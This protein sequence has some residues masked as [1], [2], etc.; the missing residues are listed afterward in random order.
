MG[1]GVSVGGKVAVGIRVS[2]GVLVAVGALA[3]S[4]AYTSSTACVWMAPISSSDGPHAV[5]K[6]LI[7][8]PRN[9]V[10]SRCFIVVSSAIS[11]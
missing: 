4:V 3:V 6:A 11:S 9:T 5:S 2:V 10:V 7:H 8:S 1:V